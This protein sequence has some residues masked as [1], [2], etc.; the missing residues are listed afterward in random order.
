[1]VCNW[2]STDVDDLLRRFLRG[3][4]FQSSVSILLPMMVRPSCWMRHDR[5]GLVVGVG[6]FVV[7]VGRAEVERLH[8][9][10]ALEEALGEIDLEI[11]L[12][13]GDF[14]DV[15]MGL[16]VVADL[17]ALAHDALH[18]ADV[19]RGLGADEQEGCP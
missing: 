19:V 17:V 1:M 8:A 16:G 7:V 9:Q 2:A 11:E 13:V 14:A 15:G 12:A 5:R 18:E 6:L 10:L 4:S 3:F